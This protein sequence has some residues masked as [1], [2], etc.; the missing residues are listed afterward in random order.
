MSGRKCAPILDMV[1]EMKGN[2]FV[3]DRRKRGKCPCVI[4]V[5]VVSS[6][7]NTGLRNKVINA[8]RIGAKRVK[9]LT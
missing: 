4:L 7:S 2:S 8:A 1:V 6:E 9:L 3:N 5:F